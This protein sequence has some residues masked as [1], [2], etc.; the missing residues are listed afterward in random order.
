MSEAPLSTRRQMRLGAFVQELGHHIAAWRRDDATH[1]GYDLQHYVEIARIAER[2]RFDMLFFGDS[3]GFQ[4]PED[5][6]LGRTSRVLRPDPL[7]VL[8]ALVP[9]TQHIGLVATASTSFIPPYL[10]ARQFATLDHL[11][12]GRAGWNIVTSTSD[13]EAWNMGLAGLPEHDERYRIAEEFMQ[14]A[15]GL[16]DSWEDDAFV[17]DKATGRYFDPAKLHVLGHEGHYFRSRGPLNAPRPVQGYPVL[18]QAGSSSAG[19]QFAARHAEVIFAAQQSIEHARQFLAET[20]VRVAAVG[21]DP[22]QVLV[23]PGVMPVVGQSRA[24]AQ[25]RVEQQ[26]A[27]IQDDIGW[28]LL[29]R[30]IGGFDLS[31]LPA[32]APVPELPPTQGNLSRQRLLLEAARAEGLTVGQLFRRVAGTR[33]HW[34]V[35]GTAQDVADELQAHFEAEAADGFNIMAP[36]LPGS[37]SDFVEGVV[38][39]LQQRGLFRTQYTHTSL[40]GHLGLSRPAHPSPRPFSQRSAQAAA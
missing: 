14:V 32:D 22:A 33:G 21:R 27:L 37:L 24:H 18:I 23:M 10:L 38:P 39:V 2:G 19:G 16:W 17:A 31:H 25:E 13:T 7:T 35:A 9:V 5:E 12:G 30:H 8:A 28:A 34:L 20:R 15:K 3:L 6:A 36:W 11:S 40:R 26:Q 1:H 29:K 4:Y